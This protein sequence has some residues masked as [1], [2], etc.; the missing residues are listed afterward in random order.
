MFICNEIYYITNR[1]RLNQNFENKDIES[2]RKIDL[3]YYIIRV[4]YW[5]WLM[6]G[7]FI[8]NIYYISLFTVGFIKFPLYHI[9]KKLYLIYDLVLPIISISLLISLGIS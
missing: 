8:P 2:I 7:I 5:G 1:D 3:V 9:D 6:Y 4:L